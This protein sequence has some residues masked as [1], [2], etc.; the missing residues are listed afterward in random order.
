[1][2]TFFLQGLAL[3][4]SAALSPGPFQSL[5]IRESLLGGLRRAAPVTFAPLLADFERLEGELDRFKPSVVFA[6][7]ADLFPSDSPSAVDHGEEPTEAR[8]P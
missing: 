5:V 1:M 4:V 2:L 6:P 8:P 3:G 7:I